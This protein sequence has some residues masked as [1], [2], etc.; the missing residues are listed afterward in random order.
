MTSDDA[1]NVWAG[2]Y[3]DVTKNDVRCPLVFTTRNSS[4][5]AHYVQYTIYL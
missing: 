2:L 1:K 3:F 5:S 4:S